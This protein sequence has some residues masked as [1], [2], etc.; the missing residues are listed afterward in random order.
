MPSIQSIDTAVIAI[1]MR[2]P[3]ATSNHVE[4]EP[5]YVITR[6]ALSDGSVGFGEAREC[7]HI[8]GETEESIIAMIRSEFAPALV[9]RDALDIAGFHQVM[10]HLAAGNT[11]AKSCMDIA[12]H[13]AVGRSTGLSVANLLGGASRGGIASSKAVSVGT[14]QAMVKQAQA[15]VA[16]GFQTLKLKTGVDEAAELAAVAAVREAVGDGVHLKLDANQAWDLPTATRFI[17]KAARFNIQMIEQPLPA[18]DY[19]GSAELRKRIDIPV[20]LDEGVRS[21]QDAFRAIEAGACD[22]INIKLVKT[23]GLHPAAKLVAVAESAGVTCQIGTLDST[24]GSAAA[25]HLVHAC[26]AL[27]FA[28]INGPSRLAYD[29]AAGFILKDGFADIARGPGLGI[30]ID[31]ARLGPLFP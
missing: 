4:N 28:E 31:D 18:F 16:A 25:V 6:L 1:P 24:I 3:L 11:A 13:D 19:R 10:N 12:L 14:T 5:R 8:T 30:T 29:V 23:G 22:Y 20:M 27:R 17:D 2:E 21:P 7:K 9:G 15:F 26:P